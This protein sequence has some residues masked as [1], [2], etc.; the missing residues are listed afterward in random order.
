L[1]HGMTVGEVA[2]MF[3]AERGL[4]MK[5]TIIPVEGWKREMWF[6][7]TGLPW[8]NPSPNM[9]NLT[10]AILYPG[11]GLLEMA[12]SV[13][14]G[15]DTPFEVFG[16]PYVDELHFA[17]E[18]NRQEI[19]GVRFVPI[20]FKP[21]ASVFEG[22][23]CGG[24]YVAVTDREE[25]PAVDIGLAAA[26]ILQRNYVSGFETRKFNTLLLDGKILE[27]VRRGMGRE[28]IRAGWETSL[29]GFRKRRETFL[30]YR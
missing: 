16:A 3:Q 15:T 23:E 11:V 17:A 22:R 7:E 25:L 13:G 21:T 30:L 2:R 14:R 9:R 5:L 4:E 8:V 27:L 6:D 29:E 19:P 26:T 18:L 28:E 10:E 24:V 1:R 20:R 12:I